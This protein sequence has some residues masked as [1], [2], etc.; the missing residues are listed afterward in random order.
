MISSCNTRRRTA[1]DANPCGTG[2]LLAHIHPA[3]SCDSGLERMCGSSPFAFRF[4]CR[5]GPLSPI[6]PAE[7]VSGN[8]R[9]PHA[10]GSRFPRGWGAAMPVQRQAAAAVVDGTGVNERV[11]EALAGLLEYPRAPFP[12]VAT[13]E[14]EGLPLRAGHSAFSLLSSSASAGSSGFKKP[15]R[16]KSATLRSPAIIS[17]SIMRVSSGSV[18]RRASSAPGLR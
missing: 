18:S 14:A 12:D 15:S 7:R 10:V 6:P 1:H 4:H 13:D 17:K 8:R 2:G 16:T 3:K 5:D 11:G 9:P